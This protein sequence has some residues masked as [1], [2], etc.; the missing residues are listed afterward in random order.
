MIQVTTSLLL[1]ALPPGPKPATPELRMLSRRETP[2]AI[3]LWA[4]KAT[5]EVSDGSADGITDLMLPWDLVPSWYT[6]STHAPSWTGFWGGLKVR[7]RFL[8]EPYYP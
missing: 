5:F 2:K 4:R 6:D 7:M 1:N 3:P 8:P